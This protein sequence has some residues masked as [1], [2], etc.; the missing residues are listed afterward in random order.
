MLQGARPR[1]TV[2]GARE[3]AGPTDIR[4]GCTR[5]EPTSLPDAATAITAPFHPSRKALSAM[6]H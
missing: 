4:A 6:E 1:A 5:F 2:R 3:A